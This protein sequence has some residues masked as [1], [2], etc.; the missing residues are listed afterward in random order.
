[1]C[2]SEER[3]KSIDVNY[4]QPVKVAERSKT[5]WYQESRCTVA[6][7]TTVYWQ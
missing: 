4:V 5:D 6:V 1:M 3:M 7:Y 2:C